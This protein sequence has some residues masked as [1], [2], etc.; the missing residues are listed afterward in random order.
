MKYRDF[1]F[2][3]NYNAIW[4]N[5]NVCFCIYYLRIFFLFDVEVDTNWF[6]IN[7]NGEN[8]TNLYQNKITRKH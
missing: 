6:E 1:C 2:V 3:F 4:S 5:F 7:N 8:T